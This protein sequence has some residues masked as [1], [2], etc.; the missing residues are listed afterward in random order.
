MAKSPKTL[1]LEGV[2]SYNRIMQNEM[3]KKTDKIRIFWRVFTTLACALMLIFIFSNS[4]RTAEESSVQSSAVVDT[5]QDVVSVIAPESPIATATGE[6]Y[7]KLHADVRMLAHFS[8][9]MLLGALFFFCWYSYTDKKIWLIAPAVG[10]ILTPMID[11]FLQILSSGR[12]AEWLDVAVDTVGGLCGG[13]VALC[14]LTLGIHIYRK[15]KQ[16]AENAQKAVE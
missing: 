4:L 3:K 5:I 12:A 15:R 13:C 10:T 1:T 9:F 16:K 6:A 11:E 2:L 7:D 14:A 8:E